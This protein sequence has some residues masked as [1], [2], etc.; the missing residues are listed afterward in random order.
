MLLL[1]NLKQLFILL[2][3]TGLVLQTVGCGFRLRGSVNV[4]PELKAVHI[5]GIAE[6]A[7]LAQELKKVLQRSDSQVFSTASAATSIITISN[8]GFKRRVLT[9]D[10]QGRAAE[11]ELK[12]QF[13]FQI[14]KRDAE[15]MVV[16]QDIELTRDYRFDPENVLAT[17]AEEEQIRREMVQFS[18]RQMMRRVES[19]LKL[20]RS[21]PQA[22]T[23]ASEP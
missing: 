18:V 14:T 10:A 4:P 6:Y 20:T 16:S 8:E 5:A 17:D 13:T 22:P 12:Y 9:V 1:S 7:Q 19:Q 21:E 2:C 23:P 15:I 11:Y 3:I